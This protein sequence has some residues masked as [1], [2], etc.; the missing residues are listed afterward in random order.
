MPHVQC[1]EVLWVRKRRLH[2]SQVD[3][4]CGGK[5]SAVRP[6]AAS[7]VETVERKVRGVQDRG[8]VTVAYRRVQ[9]WI[10]G[11]TAC[12]CMR[13]RYRFRC[14][15]SVLFQYHTFLP[16]VSVILRDRRPHEPHMWSHVGSCGSH[17]GHTIFTCV[18]MPDLTCDKFSSHVGK[19]TCKIG[20]TRVRHM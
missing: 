20:T 8:N 2:G 1:V 14:G 4:E 17:A 15:F 10:G 5:C 7:V 9:A 16:R 11:Q 3:V 6:I 13:F 18:F 12:A 19:R